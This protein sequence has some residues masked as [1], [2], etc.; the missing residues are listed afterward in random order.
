M[1]RV[2]TT[3]DTYVPVCLY[4]GK[5]L[6]GAFVDGVIKEMRIESGS[7]IQIIMLPLVCMYLSG[8]RRLLATIYP[9][10]IIYCIVRM[11]RGANF[12]CTYLWLTCR[13]ETFYLQKMPTYNFWCIVMMCRMA[14]WRRGASRLALWSKRSCG[15]W[16]YNVVHGMTLCFMLNDEN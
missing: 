14:L 1:V 15:L 10:Y 2:C 7:L 13:Y 16:L 5:L 4:C 3:T 9:W 8:W 11:F 6:P 12:H